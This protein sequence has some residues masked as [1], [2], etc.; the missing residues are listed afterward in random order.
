M[1][2]TNTKVIFNLPTKVKVA[3]MRRA[4]SEGIT[5]S[6]VLSHAARA[7]SSGALDIEAVDARALKPSVARDLK[8]MIDDAKRGKNISPDFTNARD[9]IAWLKRG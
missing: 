5:L 1:S 4:K 6:A 9:A 7:Y 2:T 3:A 8:R